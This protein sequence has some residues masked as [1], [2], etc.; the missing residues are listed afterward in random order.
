MNGTADRSYRE[1]PPL[2]EHRA[3]ICMGPGG[4]GKTTCSAALALTAAKHRKKTL[5]CTLDPAHRLC[6]ALGLTELPHVPR[7][8]PSEN[9][10]EA[11]LDPD[12]P[13]FA[14]QLDPAVAFKLSLES[15]NLPQKTIRN[16][17]ENRLY[18]RIV[19]DIEGV[20]AYAAAAQ[21]LDLLRD[22]Q[23][24]LVV[25]DTPPTRHI[26]SILKAPRI[27]AGAVKSPL[28]RFLA[29]PAALTGKIG[30]KLTGKR[31]LKDMSLVTGASFLKD[32][33]DFVRIIAEMAD[34]LLRDAGQAQSL[35]SS[36]STAYIIVTIPT[37]SR[38]EECVSL[39]E[40]LAEYNMKT[41]GFMVNRF[42]PI[43]PVEAEVPD[44]QALAKQI[45]EMCSKYGT[46][47]NDRESRDEATRNECLEAARDLLELHRNYEALVEKETEVLQFLY[48]KID[49]GTLLL[50]IPLLDHDLEVLAD[51]AD[52]SESISRQ[53]QKQSSMNSLRKPPHGS[54]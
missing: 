35:L 46:A 33:G 21:I 25:L 6:S 15:G 17:S 54:A 29:A 19:K 8:L 10:K 34:F 4:V 20:Y 42:H 37:L 5:V 51:L 40:N 50:T 23:W 14:M 36:E 47:P 41:A 49:P 30:M 9:L 32:I 44:E 53:L 11:G 38:I 39:S 13:L 2:L 45:A 18:R 28:F 27:L 48:R 43:F 31:V 12:L 7:P 22:D 26:K 16:L 1:I 52:V 3:I 24:E